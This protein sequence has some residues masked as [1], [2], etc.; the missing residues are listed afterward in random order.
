[1]KKTEREAKE[2][3]QKAEQEKSGDKTEEEKDDL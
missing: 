2:A 3:E 1:L